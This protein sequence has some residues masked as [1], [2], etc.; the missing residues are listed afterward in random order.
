MNIWFKN[1]EDSEPE[2]GNTLEVFLLTFLK[3]IQ[4]ALWKMNLNFC[5]FGASFFAMRFNGM[6]KRIGLM[7]FVNESLSNTRSGKAAICIPDQ[8]PTMLE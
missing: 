6:Q 4:I 2:M 3:R 8:K 1:S 5:F 7:H